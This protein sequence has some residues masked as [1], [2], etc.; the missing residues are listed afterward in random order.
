M[1]ELSPVNK[2]SESD[3]TGIRDIFKLLS[4]PMRLQIIYMLE[5]RTMNVSEIVERL[6]LEQ[7]AVSHQLILL[8]KGHLIS[9]SQVGKTVSYSLNDSHI[10]DILNEALEHN[11]HIH[12]GSD[13][14]CHQA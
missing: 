4:H 9:T 14:N 3:V 6:G 12:E 1:T 2:L 5:Q 7:S 10:L 8:R 11:Q 13:E